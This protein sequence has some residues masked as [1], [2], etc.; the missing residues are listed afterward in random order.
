V[1]EPAFGG[2]AGGE[3]GALLAAA[4]EGFAAI[5]TEAGELN[6]GTV[7]G[8]ALAGQECDGRAVLIGGVEG[9]SEREKDR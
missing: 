3:S 7:A 2:L 6:L 5:E 9:E 4:E 8:V 1:E